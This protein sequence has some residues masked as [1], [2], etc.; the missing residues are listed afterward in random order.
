MCN[1]SLEFKIWS[2]PK[3]FFSNIN[4]PALRLPPKERRRRG[5]GGGERSVV[6]TSLAVHAVQVLLLPCFR[7]G[8]LVG[9]TD[10]SV[11]VGCWV[12][13]GGRGG[14]R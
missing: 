1:T 13:D 5:G 2:H 14:A 10:I 7:E 3:I 12:V 11:C 8:G 9:G 6:D 4:R